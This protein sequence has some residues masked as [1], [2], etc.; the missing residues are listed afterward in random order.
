MKYKCPFTDTVQKFPIKHISYKIYFH[1]FLCFFMF[2]E[3]CKV[4][5]HNAKTLHPI[6]GSYIA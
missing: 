5:F 6:P 4:I 3:H 2:S 1:S